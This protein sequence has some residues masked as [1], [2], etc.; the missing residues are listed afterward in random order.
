MQEVSSRSFRLRPDGPIHCLSLKKLVGSCS[1]SRRVVAHRYDVLGGGLLLLY[2][3]IS[4]SC[5]NSIFN[6]WHLRDW[7]TP[8]PETLIAKF[9]HR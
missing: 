5:L 8:V 7:Q 1:F 6:G 9:K 2:N 3:I 4:L